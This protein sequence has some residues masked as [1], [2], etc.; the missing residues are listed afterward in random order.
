M[1]CCRAGGEPRGL[2]LEEQREKGRSVGSLP[3]FLKF[4]N[5]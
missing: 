5:Y 4:I 3:G 1:F 2:D